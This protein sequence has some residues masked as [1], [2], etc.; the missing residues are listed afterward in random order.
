MAELNNYS[1]SIEEWAKG[2]ATLYAE[3]DSHRRPEEF[4]NATMAHISVIG[5]SIRRAHYNNLIKASVHAFCWMCC[6]VE[7]CNTTSDPIFKVDHSL[8][9]I[10]GIKFPLI[11]GHCMEKTCQCDPM[12]MDAE[13][14]KSSKYG[15]LL[16]EWKNIQSSFNNFK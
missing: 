6:Y 12:K 9:E 4:W 11:C 13:D 8:S 15:E 10:V 5:E 3:P 1:R 14:D 16:K 7:K 2:F